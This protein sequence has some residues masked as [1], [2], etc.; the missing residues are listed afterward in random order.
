MPAN[1]NN[2]QSIAIY[3]T[4]SKNILNKLNNSKSQN[5]FTQISKGKTSNVIFKNIE[6]RMNAATLSLKLSKSNNNKNKTM[7]K[8]SSIGK[9][10]TYSDLKKQW[11]QNRNNSNGIPFKSF[12][13]KNIFM[14]PYGIKKLDLQLQTRGNTLLVNG[15]N[16]NEK[17]VDLLPSKSNLFISPNVNND[18]INNQDFKNVF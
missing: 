1:S 3:P 10:I 6:K 11:S 9:K 16:Q 2:Y 15:S 12:N 5:S 8:E 7:C 4:I 17:L 14:P 18:Y 13:G